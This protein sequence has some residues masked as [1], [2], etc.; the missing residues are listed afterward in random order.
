MKRSE[1]L[2][3]NARH[4]AL[5][6]AMFLSASVAGC[7][8]AVAAGQSGNVSGGTVLFLAAAAALFFT[9]VHF[10]EFVRLLRLSDREARCEW[11][12]GVRPRI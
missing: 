4:E 5:M 7:V 3:R 8:W 10:R 11:H 1:R 9:G 6:G 2:L 12:R